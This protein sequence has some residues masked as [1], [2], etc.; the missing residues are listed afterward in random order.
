MEPS[1]DEERENTM[2][3]EAALQRA[4]R[5][6]AALRSL[7]IHV[8]VYVIVNVLLFLIN[9]VTTPHSLWFYWPLIGW[10]IGLLIHAMGVFGLF[11]GGWLGPE[12]EQRKVNEYMSRD[13]KP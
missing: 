10:G 3:N 1:K 8:T 9:I 7:Y 12:W 4:R 11:G 6:V 2:D 5:H 13:K